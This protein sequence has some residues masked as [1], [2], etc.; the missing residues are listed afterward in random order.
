MIE[1]EYY[2]KL[3][4]DI[5]K[6]QPF[7]NNTELAYEII[8]QKILSG[9]WNSGDKI[10]QEGLSNSFDMSRTPI[11]DALARLEQE[12]F[13]VRNER[14][15]YQVRQIQLKDYID[16]CEFRLCLET[17]AA[18][19]AA[20][21]ISDKQLDELKA[22]L[23]KHENTSASKNLHQ[24]LL[25]DN[26]FHRIIAEASDNDYIYKTIQKYRSKA[27]FN[28]TYLVKEHSVKYVYNKHLAIYQAIRANDEEQAEKM[29]RS[30]LLFY[31][32]NIYH[33]YK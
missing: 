32:K 15:G 14:N 18:Y 25:L 12:K 26:E 9:E 11:R 22:N 10:H 2:Q 13:L 30:H 4:S 16:F 27:I 20:R 29:M 7:L 23:E 28:M 33:V 3:S 24:I 1:K 5:L 6:E 19:M 8:L 21:N 31:L 17:K